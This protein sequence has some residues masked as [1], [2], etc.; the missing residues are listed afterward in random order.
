ML[1]LTAIVL[2][3]TASIY[4]GR[5]LRLSGAICNVPVTFNDEY[6]E[7]EAFDS[8]TFAEQPRLYTVPTYSVSTFRELCKL[9]II[10][11]KI[12][13]EIY[14]G[15][16]QYRDASDLFQ[17]A[18]ILHHELKCWLSEIPPHLDVQLHSKEASNVLPHTLALL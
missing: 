18:L 6:E 8:T 17:T 16:K 7:L 13:S 2:D 5:P 11:D 3:K 10:M 14:A 4:Q 12:L 1:M 15:S 9:S